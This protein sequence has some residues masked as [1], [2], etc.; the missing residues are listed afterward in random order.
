MSPPSQTARTCW[1][2]R[3][4]FLLP[5]LGRTELDVRPPGPP[6]GDGRGLDV[7]GARLA[8]AECAPASEHLLSEPAIVRGAWPRRCLRQRMPLIDWAVLADD[9]DAVRDD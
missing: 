3:Q 1:S 7:D 2:A 4:A 8:R 6:V 9:Y 5:C